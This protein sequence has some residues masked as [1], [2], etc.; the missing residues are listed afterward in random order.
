MHQE[1]FLIDTHQ[2]RLEGAD[3]RRLPMM[4]AQLPET[5]GIVRCWPTWFRVLMQAWT[6]NKFILEGLNV[7]VV[8]SILEELGLY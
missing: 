3:Q 7:Q 8:L 2:R 1:Y 5:E 4:Y 6:S